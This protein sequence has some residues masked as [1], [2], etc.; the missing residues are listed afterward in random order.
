MM[1]CRL[2]AETNTGIAMVPLYTHLERIDKSLA[3][4]GIGPQDPVR[5]EQLFPLDQW[6]YHDTEVI[7]AAA[8]F[9][10]LGPDSRVLDLGA[11]IGG[12]AR[13]LAH[14][15]GCH[16]TALEL[17]PQ[18][19]AIATNLTRRCGLG[20]RVAHVCGDAL[21]YPIP[22]AAFDAVVSWL[23]VLHM[24]D[25]PRLCRR[26]ARSLRAGGACYIEDLCMRAPFAGDN[27]RDLREIV[28][29]ITVTSIDDY[30]TDFRAAGFIDIAATDPTSDWAPY[31]S[32]RLRAWRENHASYAA[33]HGEA[34][35]AAQETFYAVIDRL[36][37]TGSLGGIRLTANVP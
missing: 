19:N 30:V 24:P 4:L 22:D 12:P 29:G 37:R 34:A 35:Y 17:Q 14:T 18:L 11:G 15:T 3:A 8:E 31:A 25:R 27:L 13:Y 26:M 10:C 33:L 1:G 23:A 5:P 16:V 6:H 36:Y 21:S 7:R 2:M 9:L 20:D 32:A 28:F